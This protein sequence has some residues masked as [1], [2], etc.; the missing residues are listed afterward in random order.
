MSTSATSTPPPSNPSAKK[1]KHDQLDPEPPPLP[2]TGSILFVALYAQPS[3]KCYDGVLK[4]RWAFLLAPDDKPETH[5]RQY[6]VRETSPKIDLRDGAGGTK[7]LGIVG[8]GLEELGLEQQR[9]RFGGPVTTHGSEDKV[10]A[11]KL[12]TWGI[13]IQDIRMQSSGDARVRILLPRVQDVESFEALIKDA[14]LESDGTRGID[15]NHVVWMKD[16]W[17]ALV[18]AGD[19]LGVGGLRS[20]AIG[21][22]TV[23][24]TAM[25]FVKVQE[26]KGRFEERNLTLRVPTWGLLERR[27]LVP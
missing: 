9:M 25:E 2:P 12:S 19:M 23:E 11:Q 6:H 15:W 4:Y 13:E 20:E 5:G 7:G 17:I 8:Q 16:V 1:R 3:P 27:S 21:W 18:G 26:S 24:K 14:F 10:D 22:A